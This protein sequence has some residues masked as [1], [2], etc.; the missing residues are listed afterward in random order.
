MSSVQKFLY[1]GLKVC[2]TVAVAVYLVWLVIHCGLRVREVI[3]ADGEH[4]L[5]SDC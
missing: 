4:L 2:L 1:V 5:V 3:Q